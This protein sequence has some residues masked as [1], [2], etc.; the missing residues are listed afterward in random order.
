MSV[1]FTSSFPLLSLIALCNTVPH[2]Q[3]RLCLASRELC[4]N[5]LSDKTY[6]VHVCDFKQDNRNKLQADLAGI[7]RECFYFT[8]YTVGWIFWG[9]TVLHAIA[10]KEY[11][12]LIVWL[13]CDCDTGLQN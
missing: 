7:L 6:M 11:C 12:R 3:H 1:V 9:G 13:R 4:L 5:Y 8:Q 10:T 2:V